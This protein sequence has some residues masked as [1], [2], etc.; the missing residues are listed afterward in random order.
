MRLDH[1]DTQIVCHDIKFEQS[2]PGDK[3][4]LL[5][6]AHDITD[7]F[8][9]ITRRIEYPF[10][11]GLFLFVIEISH[12]DR[13]VGFLCNIVK[14]FFQSFTRL[15]VPSGVTASWNSFR[16]LNWPTIWS[17]TEVRLLRSTGTP[18][19]QSNNRLNGKKNHSFLIRNWRYGQSR[20]KTVFLR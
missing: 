11:T 15:R 4:S 3:L 10:K 20:Y 19:N 8:I 1:T 7:I 18:P 9:R 6:N 17:V 2:F 13:H 16:R 12:Q 5:C 14:S